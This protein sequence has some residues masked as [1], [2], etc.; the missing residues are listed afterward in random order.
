MQLGSGRYPVLR[1][2]HLFHPSSQL[3]PAYFIPHEKATS[4]NIGMGQ[5]P[6]VINFE[7]NSFPPVS[8]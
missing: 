7:N 2:H 6:Q 5:L 1:M 3:F 4:I 8:W